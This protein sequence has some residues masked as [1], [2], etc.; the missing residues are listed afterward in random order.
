MGIISKDTRKITLFYHS[1][2]ALGKQT[3]AYVTTAKMRVL[4]ID[5]AKT[6]VT[7]TQW[8]EIADGLGIGVADLVHVKHP[9]F[10]KEYG[11][12]S[13]DLNTDDWLNILRNKPH[14][15][16][17]PIVVI[18]NIFFKVNSPSHFV[19]LMEGQNADHRRA[20]S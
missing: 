14:L 17:C 6:K 18:G 7:G 2:T 11:S 15:L 20:G 4:A 16:I 3:Y 9:D 19:Q 8:I 10:I 12:P 5:I 13:V 1:G